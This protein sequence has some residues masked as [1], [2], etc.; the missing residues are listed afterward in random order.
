MR[1][2]VTRPE[3]DAERTAAMLRAS[4]HDVLVQPLL[5][6]T[7]LPPPRELPK[8]AA[9]VVTSQNGIRALARWPQSVG[10]PNVPVFVAGPATARAVAELGFGD[11]RTG[12]NDAESLAE[13][14]IDGFPKTAGSLVYPA[15]RDRAGA[16]SAKLF[17]E[18]Y[19]IRTI[20]AYRADPAK[21][22]DPAVRR[23]FE[24]GS[25]DGVLLYSQRTAAALCD[26]AVAA[27]IA[28]KLAGP[29]Y[30]VISGQ[31]GEALRGV[32]TRV[33]VAAHPDEDSLLA[34]IPRAN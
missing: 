16:L 6:V 32:A 23:A 19:D 10:W 26:L 29:A 34:L 22:L 28:G 2:F 15:A 24:S 8:P 27:G 25:L 18:G 30:Y 31:V 12:A 33:H 1:L 13:T 5:T 21:D 4:G 17:A 14:I 3:P 20:E 9:L 7:F 11:V